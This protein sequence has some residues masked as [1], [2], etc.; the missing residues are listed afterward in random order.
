MRRFLAHAAFL[1]CAATAWLPG[2]RPAENPAAFLAFL[3]LCEAA[4]LWQTARGKGRAACGIGVILFLFLAVWQ[5]A[6][7]LNWLD[8]ILFPTPEAVF[9]VFWTQRRQMAEGVVSSLTLL[10]AGYLLAI[11]M[12]SVCGMAL[13]LSERM[14]EVAL[15]I[16]RVLTP[17]SPIVYAPYLVAV[18]PS[19]RSAASAVLFIGIFLPTVLS[20]TERARHIDPQVL[21]LARVLRL[22]RREIVLEVSAPY[23][24]PS[25]LGCLRQSFSTSFMLL[26]MA[27]MLGAR[28]GMG[29][30]IRKFADYADYA[31]VAAGIILV[32]LVI[33]GLN[34]LLDAAQRRLIR[35]H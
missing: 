35:W 27:E 18:M 33:T 30:F 1:L 9:M 5:I 23:L 3:A 12:G 16:A 26:T 24:L 14:R 7:K 25:V 17:I 31:K 11:P 4:V 22:S 10:C 20:M 34:R 28:S 6:A 32:A 21:E 13:G 2:R 15:P 29:Y 8:P 19:F